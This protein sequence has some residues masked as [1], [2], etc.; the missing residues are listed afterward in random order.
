MKLKFISIILK[1][2]PKE[3]SLNVAKRNLNKKERLQFILEGFPGIGP[4]TAKKLLKKFKTLKNIFNA[5]I[6]ELRG[7]IGKKADVFNLTNE[8]Y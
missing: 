1:R 7:I 5:E 2:K 8:D 6:D 4:K 3:I